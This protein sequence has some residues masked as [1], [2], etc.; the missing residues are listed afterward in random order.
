MEYSN[1]LSAYQEDVRCCLKALCK[2]LNDLL[3]ADTKLHGTCVAGDQDICVTTTSIKIL[4]KLRKGSFYPKRDDISN[5]VQKCLD[6][7][8]IKIKL[9]GVL[10]ELKREIRLVIKI[11]VMRIH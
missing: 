1:K 9:I 11:K 7:H 4:F 3:E 8:K 10:L 6:I 2:S 5:I